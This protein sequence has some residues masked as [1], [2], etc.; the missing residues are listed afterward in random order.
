MTEPDLIDGLMQRDNESIR[1]FVRQYQPAVIK[2]AF[3]FT[4]N[5]QD[6]EDISQEVLLEVTR[7]IGRYRRGAS[8]GTWVTRIAINRSLDHLR[9]EHRRGILQS[10]SIF[11]Q[12][13][14]DEGASVTREP[15][16][17]DHPAGDRETRAILDKAVNSLPENQR[18]A[19]ILSKYEERTYREIA[20][21]MNVSLA[22]VES[23]IH[24]AKLNLQQ[25]LAG[26]FSEYV[27]KKG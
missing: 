18:I 9:R 1:A 14:G 22:S 19:F 24:R 26:Y 8:L 20:E 7:S 13:R 10:L 16:S 4:G 25:R 27:K 5:M 11:K 12:G 21:V 17:R 15:V 3:H 6:A 2:T 23:L